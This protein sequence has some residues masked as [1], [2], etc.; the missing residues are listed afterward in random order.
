MQAAWP[1]GLWQEPY[2]QDHKK[3]PS[4]QEGSQGRRIA[5][6]EAHQ[7]QSWPDDTQVTAIGHQVQEAQDQAVCDA[8]G[9]CS[10]DP[11]V[12]DSICPEVGIRA[13][14]ATIEEDQAN[15]VGRAEVVRCRPQKSEDAMTKLIHG[16]GG[17]ELVVVKGEHTRQRE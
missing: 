3:E 14:T 17:E 9:K 16:M 5:D 10:R 7:S 1:I 4:S 2:E 11:E 6:R 12:G 8:H 13:D 15:Q